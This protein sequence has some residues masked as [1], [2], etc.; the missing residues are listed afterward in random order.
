MLNQVI[1]VGRIISLED[2]ENNTILSIAI[3]RPFKNENGEYETDFINC[4]LL[5]GIATNTKEYCKKGDIVGVKGR[6]QSVKM[7]SGNAIE[8]AVEKITFLSSSKKEEEGE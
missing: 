4:K 6:I 7:A 3:P 5:G 2:Q 8:V 1:L